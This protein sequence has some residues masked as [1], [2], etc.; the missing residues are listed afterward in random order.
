MVEPQ[1]RERVTAVFPEL[2]ARTSR[3]IGDGWTVDTYDVDGEWIVQFPRDARAADRLR[4]QIECCPS[5]RRSCRRWSPR[6]SI[7]TWRSRR[8]PTT[9]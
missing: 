5:S 3:A 2:G 6:R 9:G 7:P 1:A 8:W 4:A